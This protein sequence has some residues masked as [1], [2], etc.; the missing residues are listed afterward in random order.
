MPYSEAD[1]RSKLIDPQLKNAGRSEE[2]IIREWYFTDGR[3]LVGGKRWQRCF[4]DYVLTYNGVK[5]AI[6]EAKSEDKEPT[7]G[8]EQVKQYGQKLSLRYVYSS[9]G[10][11][12]YAFDLQTGTGDYIDSYPSP[13]ELYHRIIDPA[14]ETVQN[15]LSQPFY[16]DGRKPR[17]YQEIA[18]NTAL[19][20]IGQGKDRILLTLATGTGK[21]FI[22]FQ[23]VR[24]LFQAR[25]SRDNSGRRPR[26]LFLADRNILIDQAMNDFNPMEKDCIKIT[27]EEIRKRWGKVPTNANV[28][29]AIYQAIIGDTAESEEDY[30]SNDIK[31]YFAQ[32]PADF[33]DLVIIDE[34]HRGGANENGSWHAILERFAPAVHLG[35]T[36]TPK[37]EDNIDTYRYF[38]DPVYQYSLKEWI[39]DWFLSPY[40]VKRVRT[41]IDE[42]VIDSSVQVVKGEVKKDLYDVGDFDK[43]IVVQERTELIAQS[44]LKE[45]QP[46]DKTIIFCVDQPHAARMRDAINKYKTNKDPDYCVRITSDEGT[47]GRQYLE[48]FQDNDKTIPT[49]ITSSQMLTTWVDAKNVRN[50]VLLRNIWSMVEFK[51]IIGRGTRLFDGKDFFTIIDYTG[52][53][54]KFY[55]AAWD[56][57]PLDPVIDDE[58]KEPKKTKDPDQGLWDDT[59]E[60]NE[61]PKERLEVKLA[62]G[63]ELKIINVE[64]RY[65][66]EHGKPLSATEYLEKLI[67]K[68]PALYQSEEQLRTLRANPDTREK[69][70]GQLQ[71]IGID[72]EQLQTLQKM[73]QAQDS[74]IFDVL[75]HLS[76]AAPFV[77][78]EQRVSYVEQNDSIITDTANITAK[79]FLEFVLEYYEG[80]GS[81]ELIRGK[82]GDII[83]L[84]GKGSVM[85]VSKSF[86]GEKELLQAWYKVQ[87]ELFKI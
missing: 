50:I 62:D 3:K 83:K 36:A 16:F 87:E 86:G 72:S 81:Q 80:H 77:S 10:H 30:E 71:D 22:A 84:Y 5:L 11:K 4:A 59:P 75:A 69:L 25:W 54:N 60:I 41:N 79:E 49:I 76:F 33:F 38:G 13:E 51:Q 31:N 78:R 9:N 58:P 53:T 61:I 66:D 40:K 48:R 24:R 56:G 19:T 64:I 44:I 55:D 73:L 52:A 27:G 12:T 23:T 47:I 32:Y 85:D 65:I 63:R 68:L 82:I 45:I 37:R 43:S 8:L 70:L 29:F 6:I 28:F 17:Y 7:D 2:H 74:D 35:L 26:V 39:N 46:T 21:T 67:G 1:T 57:D 18:I 15:I 20:Q 42:L 14:Q 34:C